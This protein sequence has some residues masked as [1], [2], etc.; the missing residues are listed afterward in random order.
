MPVEGGVTHIDVVRHGKVV[1]PGLFCAPLEE[2]LSELGW[3]QMQQ[4][5]QNVSYEQVISSPSRRCAEFAGVWAATM[6]CEPMI[7]DDLQEMDFGQWVGRPA[8][9]IW[10]QDERLLQTLW[11]DP[12]SFIA[13]KGEAMTEFIARVQLAWQTILQQQSGR[14]FAVFTHGGVIRILLGLAL[15]IPYQK[16]LG[17]ALAYGSATR[18]KVYPDG[19]VSVYGVG[20]K[21]LADAG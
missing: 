15:D 6:S 1:T 10:Q 3:K 19:V 11:Q 13:P 21:Q 7:M 16:T 14:H 20:V 5:T 12:I 4:T 18:F 8:A 9:D 2:P 17:F